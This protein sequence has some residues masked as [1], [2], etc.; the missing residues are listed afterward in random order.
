MTDQ[1]AQ[2]S[3]PQRQNHPAGSSQKS[4]GFLLK[5]WR[6]IA[7]PVLLFGAWFLFLRLT[8]PLPLE[9]TP[10]LIM[11]WGTFLILVLAIYPRF[12]QRLTK[13]KLGDVE[14][15]FAEKMQEASA[16]TLISIP[17]AGPSEFGKRD[18]KQMQDLLDRIR[19]SP[20]QSQMIFFNVYPDIKEVKVFVAFIILFYMELAGADTVV[21]FYKSDRPI[22]RYRDLYPNEVW[23]AIDGGTAIRLLLQH[24]PDLRQYIDPQRLSMEGGIDAILG[25]FLAEVQQREN[26]LSGVTREIFNT[27]GEMIGQEEAPTL[28]GKLVHKVF[29]PYLNT[30]FIGPQLDAGDREILKEVILRREDFVLVEKNGRLYSVIRLCDI[31][32]M[33]LTKLI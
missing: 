26:A 1:T 9:S 33:T 11:V 10:A 18:A 12:W 4:D 17:E 32:R 21:V 13:F 5:F 22:N 23:G 24:D 27:A 2:Q 30:R 25:S 14:L 19:L 28:D 31:S 29:T 7:I 15:A 3:E 6:A 20:G 16:A 8:A